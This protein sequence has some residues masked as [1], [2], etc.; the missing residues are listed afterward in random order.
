MGRGPKPAKSKEAKSPVTRKSPKDGAA[1]VR[2]LEK[3]LA[4]AL[5]Q[6]QTRDRELAESQEQQ[7]ATAE[8]LRVIC[9]SPSD[10]QPVFEAIVS[11]AKQ[12]V[13][14]YSTALLRLID[15][16]LQLVA[17]SATTSLGDEALRAMYPLRLT[18][19]PLLAQAIRDR[20]PLLIEDT[21]TD[22]RIT[23][24][25]REIARQRGYRSTLSWP[26]VQRDGVIGVIGVSHSEPR[27]FS[28]DELELLRTFAAQAVIAIENVRLFNETKEALERQ[29]ATSDIL[30]VI[31]SSP[32]DLEPVLRTIVQNARKVC[33]G[34]E[35]SVFLREGNSLRLRARQGGSESVSPDFLGDLPVSPGF[36]NGRAILERRVVQVADLTQ[37][38]DFPEGRERARQ[39]GYRTNVAVPLMREGEAIGT[40]A[41][42]RA[43]VAPFSDR[44]IELLQTFANQAVI[45]IEN[46]RLFRELETR[47]RDLTEALEQQTA[48]AEVL[49]VI[50]RS[51]FDLQPVLETLIESATRLCGA[52]QGFV[53]RFDGDALRVA[54]HYGVSPEFEDYW[55]QNLIRPGSGS[56]SGR[57][58]SERR[59]IHIHDVLTEPDYGQLE[60]QKLQGFRTVLVV[61]MLREDVLVGTIAMWKPKVEPFSDKQIALLQTFADQAVIA[62]E[63][64][65]LL[66]ELQARTQELTRSVGQ[67]TAL[68]EVGRAVSSTLDLETVLSTIVSRAVQLAGL[69]AGAIYE[70]DE[71]AEVFHLR[72]TQNLPEELLEIARPLALPKGEGATGRLAVTREPVQIPDIADGPPGFTGG[73]AH[74]RGPHCRGPGGEPTAT[75][76]VRTRGDRPSAD[77]R[78]SV[79]L[80]HSERSPLP[81]NRGQEPPT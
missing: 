23:P 77:L 40:L 48:T 62:I 41:I 14:A 71:A 39:A 29:T 21:E 15:G 31:S 60:A 9:S 45:A 75:G 36:V 66:T 54:A 30:R 10:V 19:A 51:T 2:D 50:S 11:S 33:G 35:A 81:R 57:A 79:G 27:S 42:R 43:V 16:E 8:I 61:P 18:Q 76:R 12:L 20:A 59:P 72:A 37:S 3:R 46:V 28:S 58:A 13:G 34:Y 17:S 69:E 74:Q 5:G 22:P 64:A 1:T 44:Q 78:H 55:R 47:N 25:A 68:G 65:R 80:S 56:A 49:K 4:E 63:N 73:A 6:L 32:T 53:Q 38:D 67:L 7:A 26:L 70:Y 52:T 24:L